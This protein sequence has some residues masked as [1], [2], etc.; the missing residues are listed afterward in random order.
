MKKIKKTTAFLL[1]ALIA[2]LSSS[3]ISSCRF[4]N[5][6]KGSGNITTETRTLNEDFKS[7]KI[8]NAIQALVE[9]SDNTAI[10]VETDDNLQQYISTKIEKGVLIIESNK[11]YNST[12]T[13]KI[14][15]KMPVIDELIASSASIITSQNLLKTENINIKSSS[16]SLIKIDVEADAITLESS[17]GSSIKASGKALKLETSSSSGSSIDAKE[18]MTNEVISNASSGSNTSIYPILNLNA[19][20][21]SGSSINYYKIPKTVSKE[22]SSGGNINQL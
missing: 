2:A 13:P 8:S 22:E 15:I 20:A 16:G 11:N 21:S 12:K 3:C 7:I 9:Q 19:K 18:L 4:G 10:S 6:I 5:G 17:S 14:Y 1:V